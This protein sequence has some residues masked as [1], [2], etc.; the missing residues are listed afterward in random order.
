MNGGS[1]GGRAGGNYNRRATPKVKNGK[2]QKKNRYQQSQ[3]YYLT[4][5]SQLQI[6]CMNPGKDYI[7]L[8]D[9]YDIE[10]F[11]AII[12]NW[13]ELARGLNAI[14]L[15]GRR[16]SCDGWHERG[17]IHICSWQKELWIDYEE[18][19]FN[20]HEAI[21]K[22]LHVPSQTLETMADDDERYVRCFFSEENAKAY[23]LLHIFLHELGHHYDRM[24]TDKKLHSVRGESFA[25]SFALEHEK[26]IF[27]RYCE[28]FRPSFARQ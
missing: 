1:Q 20:A 4:S 17:V 5:P 11:L 9:R 8:L 10:R 3:N 13:Q 16:R 18:W 24:T 21:F 25:E 12:P 27:E 19:Y 14:V 6:D 23:Q 28:V 22:R 26:I 15:A 2:V 7:H